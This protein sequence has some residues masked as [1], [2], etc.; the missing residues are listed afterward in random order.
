MLA[1]TT[2]VG[3]PRDRRKSPTRQA[4]RRAG[5]RRVLPE[6]AGSSLLPRLQVGPPPPSGW[7]GRLIHLSTGLAHRRVLVTGFTVKRS[8]A[9][10]RRGI[11]LGKG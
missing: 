4:R 6:A 5:L 2:L 1:R 10:K 11:W 7:G 3:G 8:E 9:P